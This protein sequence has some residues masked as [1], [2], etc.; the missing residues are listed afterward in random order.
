MKPAPVLIYVYNRVANFR[1]CIEALSKDLLASN[2]K[3]YIAS[4]GALTNDIK[5][6]IEEIRHIAYSYSSS[7]AS[8]TIFARETNIGPDEN[9]KLA[10]SYLLSKYDH[11]ITL[12]DDVE[13][14]KNCLTFLNHYLLTLEKDDTVV[15]VCSYLPYQASNIERSAMLLPYRSP[16]A[17]AKWKSKEY[18]LNDQTEE[19]LSFYRNWSNFLSYIKARPHNVFV[20]PLVLR[21]DFDKAHDVRVGL[22]MFRKKLHC[23]YPP[24]SLSR[25]TGF[26]RFGL[27]ASLRPKFQKQASE[28]ECSEAALYPET[29]K[30]SELVIDA[31]ARHHQKF[32]QLAAVIPAY[33]AIRYTLYY[34]FYRRAYLTF[35]RYREL[36]R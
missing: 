14:Y 23:V 24:T 2:T 35:R 22:T 13:V 3:V 15:G 28:I 34:Y 36:L 5:P 25:N 19:N 20:L 6:V 30:E 7:F 10:H 12:E 8:L 9:K 21:H 29:L 31:L 18:L 26:N 27:N 32:S 17:F 1:R 4:D 11:I 33:L 16:Y